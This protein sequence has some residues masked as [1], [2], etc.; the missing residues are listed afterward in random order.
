MDRDAADIAAALASVYEVM[1]ADDDAL[2][3]AAAAEATAADGAGEARG[4]KQGPKAERVSRRSRSG[5]P[6]EKELP[7]ES[8]PKA[9]CTRVE[10]LA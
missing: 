10:C 5:R 6:P 2:A 4:S 7:I 1:P 8:L 9:S 3:A